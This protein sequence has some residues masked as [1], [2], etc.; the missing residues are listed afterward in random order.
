MRRVVVA[1]ATTADVA[2]CA[3]MA[4]VAATVSSSSYSEPMLEL[5][6]TA[7]TAGFPCLV[8]Q[9]FHE[10]PELHRPEILPL[11]LPEQPLLPRAMWCSMNWTGAIRPDGGKVSWG[12]HG[13]RRSHLY[14][15]RMWAAVLSRG[16]DMLAVDLDWRFAGPSPLPA[17]HELRA[18][19]GAQLD[20]LGWWDGPTERLLNVGLMWVRSSQEAISLVHRVLNR[21]FAGWEQ[22]LFTEELQFGFENITCCHS[23]VFMLDWFRRSMKDHKGK[24]SSANVRARFERE[25]L[26]ECAAHDE[27]LPEGKAPPATTRFVWNGNPQPGAGWDPHIFNHLPLFNRSWGRCTVPRDSSCGH[28]AVALKEQLVRPNGSRLAAAAYTQGTCCR[29]T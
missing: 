9:P 11:P 26:P 22:G 6:A 20:V 19:S 10:F 7:I 23:N 29:A 18:K 3:S 14:R 12:W 8:V 16:F 21:T 27:L 28:A 17:I 24:A 1:N 25:G 4:T 5:A 2:R 15:V 13:W